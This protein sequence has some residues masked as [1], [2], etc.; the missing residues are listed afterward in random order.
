MGFGLGESGG[1]HRDKYLS[2]QPFRTAQPFGT[3]RTC[4][5]RSRKLHQ[6]AGRQN[7]FYTQKPD[8]FNRS[9]F[10]VPKPI[11]KLTDSLHNYHRYLTNFVE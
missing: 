7:K 10:F 3:P 8:F 1:Y 4:I 6:L 5:M 2:A 11:N 9:G